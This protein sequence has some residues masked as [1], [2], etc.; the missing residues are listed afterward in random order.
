VGR[1]P[2]TAAALVAL[3]LGLSADA[4]RAASTQEVS[5]KTDDGVTIAGTLYLPGRPAPAVILV[6]ALSRTREDWSVVANK[7][8][9]AGF[10]ALAIDLRGHGASGPLPGGADLQQLTPM[11]ADLK[12]ARLFLASRREA[13]PSR[14]GVAGASIGANLAIL[15]A[16][17]DPAVRSLV[18]LSP[19]IDYRGLRPEAALKKYGD[20]P[21][22][23]VASQEDSYSA[24]SARELTKSGPGIRDL[25]ILNG[26][27]HG[28]NMLLRQP[29]LVG[30]VVDWFR[31]TLL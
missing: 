12:A 15:L 6:H 29:D 20:R 3:L 27:G 10:V 25:R 8:A 28:T 4:A 2:T 13:A 11:I 9:D 24:N 26:A 30:A 21:A 16:A 5:F 14:I 1:Q 23:L 18:L 31:R 7:L 19:G 17:S 22:M